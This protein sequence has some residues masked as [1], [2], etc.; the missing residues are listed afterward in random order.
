MVSIRCV[1]LLITCLCIAGTILLWL[2]SNKFVDQYSLAGAVCENHYFREC[3]QSGSLWLKCIEELDSLVRQQESASREIMS[4]WP[5]GS[6]THLIDNRL[7]VVNL[8]LNIPFAKNAENPLDNRYYRQY[9]EL[10]SNKSVERSRGSWLAASQKRLASAVLSSSDYFLY[11]QTLNF[12][13]VISDAE[14]GIPIKTLPINNPELFVFRSPKRTC[15]P[16]QKE[17][18]PDLV[19][20]IKSC[21]YCTEKRSRVRQTFMQ[22]HLWTGINVQ[23]VFVVGIP[24][25]GESN[26]FVIDGYKHRLKH[27][28]WT[29]SKKHDNEKWTFMKRLVREADQYE[30]LLVGFFHDTYFNLT[31][32]LIF[33]VRWLSAFC[34]EQIPL[35]LFI[36]DDY[37]LV[38]RNVVKFYRSHSKEY[39]RSLTGGHVFSPST[40][41]R[42]ESREAINGVWEVTFNEFP[43]KVYPKFYFG[44][45]YLLGSSIVK[46]VAVA[47]A[48]TKH[49]RID[50]AF[51]GIVLNKLNIQL[52]S[53]SIVPFYFQEDDILTDVISLPA[54]VSTD[55]MDWET[56]SFK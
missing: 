56:G 13:E 46:R 43:W 19:V 34:S 9:L 7:P 30:D 44:L 24:Y 40:V 3:T 52:K 36:D 20:V 54:S 32:K 4:T 14:K 25:P 26:I 31:T 51:L 16:C 17:I 47:S 41:Y 33:T 18:V 39:L 15:N 53:L 10:I 5:P 6:I 21:T 28:W 11:P 37:D 12:A 35:F 23:F 2:F 8:A 55:L 27:F 45:T 38:P 29:S 42:P 50:D 1:L 49:M 48:F 22:K